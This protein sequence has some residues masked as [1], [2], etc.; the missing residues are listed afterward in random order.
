MTDEE[1]KDFIAINFYFKTIRE[2]KNL[3]KVS[4]LLYVFL[5]T[6]DEVGKY[7]KS[8]YFD[9]CVHHY[10]IEILNLFNPEKQPINTKPVFK[11]KLK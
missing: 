7:M 11:N 3:R 4:K 6:P 10:D 8:N 5:T 2:E 1:V 9:N